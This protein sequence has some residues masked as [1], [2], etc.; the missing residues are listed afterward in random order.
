M[1]QKLVY[2]NLAKVLL[3]E[4]RDTSRCALPEY[5]GTHFT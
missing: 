2:K 4:I 3:N 1:V 5:S